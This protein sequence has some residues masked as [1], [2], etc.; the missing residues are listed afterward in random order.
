[1]SFVHASRPKYLGV[2]WR[3]ARSIAQNT[4]HPFLRQGAQAELAAECYMPAN[5][6]NLKGNIAQP[7]EPNDISRTWRYFISLV[8]L[9]L[10]SL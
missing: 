8:V 7:V 3:A 5:C 2:L 4:E 1:M 6:R 9:L 10:P